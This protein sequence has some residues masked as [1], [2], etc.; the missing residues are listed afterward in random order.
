MEPLS[1]NALAQ[2]SAPECPFTI[3]YSP[4]ILDDI[5]LAVTDAFFSLPR[6]GAEIGGI[7]LGRQDHSRITILDFVPI[8]CEHAFGPSFVLSPRDQAKLAELI[9]SANRN[10]RI[11]VL[12]WYHSHTR[13]EIFLSDSDLEVYN[14]FFPQA[15]QIALVLKPH[16]FEPM[17]AGF[18]FRERDG[19][20]R[21]MAPLGEF[22]L[23][24]LPM[25]P[26]PTSG[27]AAAAP[28][29]VLHVRERENGNPV[30]DVA[31]V[32]EPD[33]VP[34]APEAVEAEPVKAEIP[35]PGFATQEPARRHSRTVL[36]AVALGITLGVSAYETRGLWI[37]RLHAM[38]GDPGIEKVGLTATDH[39]GQLLIQWNG[40]SRAALES[41]RGSLR[42]VDGDKPLTVDLSRPH[43]LTGSFSYARQTGRVGVTLILPQHGGKEAR[44]ATIFAGAEPPAPIRPVAAPAPP[45]TA[46]LDALSAENQ[47]LRQDLARQVERNKT[48]D[49]AL[50]E[51]RKVIQRDEQRKRLEHQS[52]DAVK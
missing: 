49:K 50:G 30:I 18:F 6:G 17:R 8:D 24:P 44:E 19:S 9:A 23:D 47:R 11:R 10:P 5:R 12:G 48:L 7:L 16:T 46:A 2:W 40:G 4:R 3:E 37:P 27:G 21:S 38:A 33:P 31:R 22:R 25:R 32:A 20:V 42:I 35:V 29:P 39:D 15:C 14:R 41:T 36:A 45:D 1:D 34:A 52:P 28:A 51:M 26:V 43:I 13:T